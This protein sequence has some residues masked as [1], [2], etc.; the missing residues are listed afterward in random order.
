MG[1]KMK[2]QNRIAL[3]NV[4]IF[5]ALILEYYRGVT[6]AILI[7]CGFFLLLLVNIIFVIRLRKS[8]NQ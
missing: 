5:A 4:G 7:G 3:V 8:N 1:S 6:I 2:L